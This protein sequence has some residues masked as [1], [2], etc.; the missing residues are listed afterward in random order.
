MEVQKG[1]VQSISGGSAVVI[2][3]EHPETV[4]QPLIVP[5]YWRET[6][7][8][9]QAGEECYFF[10]DNEHGGYIIGRT[11]GEWDNTLRGTLTVTE[12]VTASGISLKTH[13]HT[14]SNAG[15]PTSEPN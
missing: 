11:D 13:T 12:D 1:R 2:P 14:S 5:F 8:N 9:L 3:N 6:M 10:E 15:S 7:G 4:T